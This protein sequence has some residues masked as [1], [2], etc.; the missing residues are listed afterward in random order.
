MGSP[1]ERD[2]KLC[3]YL[4]RVTARWGM[5][6]EVLCLL[7]G[8]LINDEGLGRSI[9]FSTGSFRQR[10]ELIRAAG[11]E[12]MVDEEDFTALCSLINKIYKTFQM[13]NKLVHAH[14]V[15]VVEN[16]DG[17]Q[18]YIND[19]FDDEFSLSSEG[20]KPLFVGRLDTNHVDGVARVNSGTF[21]NHAEKVLKL[22][23]RVVNLHEELAN[24]NV[25]LGSGLQV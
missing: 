23:Y 4:G 11:H 24:G 5:M 14:Y 25:Q 9:Y 22:T 20:L 13:R 19:Y 7:L 8:D 10:I 15:I 6:E 21:S 12:R 1:L 16:S 17:E 2:A 18:S 3:E